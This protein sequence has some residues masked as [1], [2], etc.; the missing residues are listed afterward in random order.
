MSYPITPVALPF[1]PVA[2]PDYVGAL[3]QYLRGIPAMTQITTAA[4]ITTKIT[5][6]AADERT[7]KPGNWIVF[8]PTGGWGSRNGYPY[9]HAFITT[10]IYGANGF[11][12]HRQWSMLKGILEPSGRRF[13]GFRSYGCTFYDFVVGMPNAVP[14]EPGTTPWEKRIVIVEAGINEVPYA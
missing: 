11:E 10:H 9:M 1:T 4:H 3:V 2:M 6:V 7:G 13:H 12:C 5:D 14:P 8:V